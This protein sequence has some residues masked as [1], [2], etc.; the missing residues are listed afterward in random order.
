V[1]HFTLQLSQQGPLLTAYI[2][3]SQARHAALT[4]AGMPVPHGIQIQ[5]LI[6]T[7]A[8]GSCVDPAILQALGLTPTGVTTIC[9][10]SS[11]AY[12]AQQY[13]VGIAVPGATATHIPFLAPNVPVI[14]AQLSAP[15]GFQALFGRDLLADCLFLYNG[16]IGYFTLAW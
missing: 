14:A 10:P 9:T 15:Q 1:P 11:Q 8:S 12:P 5:A 6:D 2:G 4:A 16:P 13:D 3:V 7:G